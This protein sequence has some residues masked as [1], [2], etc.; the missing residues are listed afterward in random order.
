MNVPVLLLIFNRPDTTQKV[1]NSI[2]TAQPKQLFV[3]ADGPR[4]Q[5]AGEAEKCAITRQV[6]A[7]VDWDCEVKTLFRKK[8]LG[9]RPAVSGG[10]NWFF[11]QVEAG[12]ILEDDCVPDLSFFK[13]CEVLLEKYKDNEAVMQIGGSNLI[14][15]K[16]TTTSFDYIFSKFVPIWGWATWRR[17]WQKMDIDL[18][19]F[20]EF[21]EK[22][23]VKDF[24]YSKPA[25]RYMLEKFEDTHYKRNSS[26]A[27][28]WFYSVLQND[29]YSIIPTKNL[30]HNIGFGED[31]TH[32]AK[33]M[34]RS[35]RPA[36]HINLPLRHPQT[37][38]SE[39]K[40]NQAFF[41][42]SQKAQI[43]LYINRYLPKSILS[44]GKRLLEGKV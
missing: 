31:A 6:I 8:N 37:I 40:L 17:A 36:T 15:E 27:Y 38:K 23:T 9:C 12:I 25:Q 7:Q 10:I 19:N 24:V 28:A 1:F 33:G 42:V 21:K 14:A 43:P 44:L 11:E 20:K 18:S 34:K 22:G 5:K 29:G 35:G 4:S 2:R 32:T 3:S 39:S 13:F 30:I 26:W 41:Y 16:F